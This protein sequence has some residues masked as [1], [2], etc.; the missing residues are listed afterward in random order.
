MGKTSERRLL[1]VWLLLSAITLLTWFLGAENR[2]GS[3]E[4]SAVVTY[5]A[6]AIVAVKVRLI[7]VEFMEARRVS[8]NL[9]L[10]MDSW[11]VLLVICLAAIYAFR[12]EMPAV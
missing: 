5:A 12:L 1:R 7:V 3:A 9:Q 4:T 10:A 11:L 8:K 2:G 6:L